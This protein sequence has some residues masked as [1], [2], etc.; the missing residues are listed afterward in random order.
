MLKVTLTPGQ[1]HRG[2]VCGDI[3]GVQDLG[4]RGGSADLAVGRDSSGLP[5]AV[6]E[7]APGLHKVRR[8]LLPC[9]IAGPRPGQ[10][11]AARLRPTALPIAAKIVI[12]SPPAETVGSAGMTVHSSA[13]DGISCGQP[14]T[15]P[16][17]GQRTCRAAPRAPNRRCCRGAQRPCGPHAPTPVFASHTRSATMARRSSRASGAA[18]GARRRSSSSAD[19]SRPA[20]SS[21]TGTGPSMAVPSGTRCP[22]LVG[23]QV[24]R[25]GEES[26]RAQVRL[27]RPE[28]CR[29][30]PPLIRRV[31]L[32]R[33]DE[34]HR[35]AAAGL[36]PAQ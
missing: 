25:Q 7:Q 29:V 3:Q 9:L 30:R 24:D 10:Y 32:D 5:P 23:G 18:I 20:G 28:P 12:G 35:A 34:R 27:H 4:L 1:G 15:I 36:S 14:R 21:P 22:C 2:G 26:R 19:L 17:A 6:P 8:D 11:P 31:R 13:A 33:P 16:S